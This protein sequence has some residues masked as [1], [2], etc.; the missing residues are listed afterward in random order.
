MLSLEVATPEIIQVNSKLTSLHKKI[1]TRCGNQP[2]KRFL[3]DAA[4]PSS[5]SSNTPRRSAL[6]ASDICLVVENPTC[7]V[8]GMAGVRGSMVLIKTTRL[9][10]R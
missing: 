2:H 7:S 5:H 9:C 4:D 10:V 8:P 1:R 6:R 3:V